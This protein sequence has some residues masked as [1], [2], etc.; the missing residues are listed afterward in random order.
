MDE[1]LV[2]HLLVPNP[3]ARIPSAGSG[4][5]PSQTETEMGRIQRMEFPCYML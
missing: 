4:R 1:Q 5:Y 2:F 3:A